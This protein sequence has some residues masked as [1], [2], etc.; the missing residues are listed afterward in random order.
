MTGPRR[1][2][3]PRGG[4]RIRGS[5]TLVLIAF[6]LWAFAIAIALAP[7]TQRPAPPDQ[8]PGFATIQGFD[9][10]GPF[11]FYALLIVLVLVVP[12]ALRPLARRLAS[13][14]AWARN[15]AIASCIGALWF[16][17][18][19]R[20]VWWVTI[21]AAA[22][23]AAFTFLRTHE[24]GFSRRDWILVPVF[25]TTFISIVD[26]ARAL[27]VER[28]TML[29]AAL[30]FAIRIAVSFLASPVSPALAFLLA[31][32]GLALQTGF[33]ARDQ[34]TFGWHALLLVGITPFVM[35]AVLRDERRARRL[36]TFVIYPIAIY[37]YANAMSVTTAEGKDRINVFEDSHTLPIAS[38]YLRGERPYRDQLPVHGLGQDG[39]IDYVVFRTGGVTAGSA[40]RARFVLS[41][42]A[43]VGTYALG[44]AMTGVPEVGLAAWLFSTLIGAQGSLRALPALFTL[45][46]IVMAIRRRNPRFLIAA[47]A[48]VV[49]CG[50]ISL[51]YA[52][53][54]FVALAIAGLRFKPARLHALRSAFIGIAAAVGVFLALLAILGVF[55][56]FFRGTFGE[57][58][59]LGPAYT[60]NLFTMPRS[61][62]DVATFPEL[63]AG[64]FRADAFPYLAWCAIAVATAVLLAMPRQRAR[65]PFVIAGLW[66]VIAAIS[67]AERHHVYFMA[68]VPA[69]LVGGAHAA[70]RR[71]ITIAPALI[72]VLMVIAL[73]TTHIGILGWVR[74]LDG[75]AEGWG[76]ARTIPRARGALMSGE[77]AAQLASAR[78]YVDLTLKRDE[79][80]FDFTNRAIFYFLLNRDNPTRY[81][82]VAYYES[83]E[84]QREVI[85]I[86]E[87]NPKIRAAL[88]PPGG[89]AVDGVA[90][91][92]RAP[93]VWQYLQQH[94]VPDFEEGGVTF[95]RRR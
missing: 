49:V 33:F 15:A 36:L 40:L 60:L 3:E 48:G 43:A 28:A 39:G 79:T 12:A 35:R 25:L 24:A 84:K 95:W 86:L 77:D 9:A 70:I 37:A 47:G 65:E 87:R 8:L 81:V 22:G 82:E 94:F 38:E 26:I 21:P 1:H 19:E 59:A 27:P 16:A 85:A 50:I 42:L 31:P 18:I 78:K 56:D 69:V 29:A 92:V 53:F 90:N 4:R 89:T 32:L 88:V 62:A 2:P 6:A 68:A 67:Y 93:L 17:L 72:A 80:F 41:T 57:I 63:L 91:E 73:P 54:T 75:P 13:G 58:L 61:L 30:V 14:R 83:E 71:R 76:E 44:A 5:E 34:R 74:R 20:N 55:A 11:R 10:H 7:A 52:L 23:I 64:L 45:A 66:I 51:D 46:L